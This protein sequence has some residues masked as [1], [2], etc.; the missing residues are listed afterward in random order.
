MVVLPPDLPKIA[1]PKEN[2]C[3]IQRLTQNAPFCVRTYRSQSTPSKVYAAV[4]K[5]I[6]FHSR[7]FYYKDSDVAVGNHD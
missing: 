2:V 7:D 1:T 6:V 3:D 5:V 4:T